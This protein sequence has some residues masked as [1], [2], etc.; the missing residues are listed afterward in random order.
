MLNY[1]KIRQTLI[2]PQ[3]SSLVSATAAKTDRT[4][5]N[6]KEF[7]EWYVVN[8]KEE[9][10]ELHTIAVP[11]VTPAFFKI[12]PLLCGGEAEIVVVLDDYCI[13]RLFSKDDEYVVANDRIARTS[14]I[15]PITYDQL[16]DH[17]GH[18]LNAHIKQ[19][20]AKRM[21]LV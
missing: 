10:D 6:W 11:F 14:T 19:N 15:V 21:E 12:S 2:D 4:F 8:G 17:Y 18:Y 1:L 3:T 5:A 13:I 7:F 9:G 16:V 20:I